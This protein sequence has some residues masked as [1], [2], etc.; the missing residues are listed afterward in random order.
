MVTEVLTKLD[1][2]KNEAKIYE[3]LV[4]KG[5]LS[6]GRIATLANINRRNAY[7]SLN[8]LIEK[9][10][11]FESIHKK[12]ST[13]QAVD[14]RKLKEIVEEKNT[15][16]ESILPDLEKWYGDVPHE[17]EVYI[18]HGIEG[19]K[20]YIRDVIRLGQDYHVI[21]G[22]GA[23]ADPALRPFMENAIKEMVKKD[24]TMGVLF[25]PEVKEAK[26]EI[27]D[28]I[29]A[30]KGWQTG[31]LPQGFSTQISVGIFGNR[32]VIFS[33]FEELGKVYEDLSFTVIVNNN[34]A[35]AMRT[36]W[37]FMWEMSDKSANKNKE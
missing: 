36:W 3:T 13:Y 34:I 8:R 19:W 20:N 27:I 18:Y 22:R 31:F 25:D 23:W 2:S 7:D 1:L 33:N 9:G 30:P 21:G 26:H 12:E 29:N 24:I 28:M 32:T 16:L 4:K 5:E 10:L 15:A 37:R 14:P 6:A 35:E 11:V 17:N